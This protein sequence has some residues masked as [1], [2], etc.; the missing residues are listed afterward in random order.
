M[1]EESPQGRVSP[2]R[3]AVIALA[4]VAAALGITVAW[5]AGNG[6]GGG[7]VS[8]ADAGC[9]ADPEVHD[10]IDAA[11][12]GQVAAL[13]PTATG[14]GYDDLSFLDP[15]GAVTGFAALRNDVLLV[16]FWATWCGPCKREMPAL[17]ALQNRYAGSSFQVVTINLDIGDG[18]PAKAADFMDEIGLDNLPL[19]ADPSF[20]IFDALR[21]RGVAIGLPATLLL[22]PDG[23]EWAVMAGP[24]EWDTPDAHRVVETALRLAE[25]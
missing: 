21:Q 15:S 12:Q 19:Y 13:L 7:P 9:S 11:A 10:A 4:L 8:V 16:N 18:G 3:R 20:A 24:A 25:T 6:G 22:G 2:A 23:C 14:R 5:W 1:T 17:S